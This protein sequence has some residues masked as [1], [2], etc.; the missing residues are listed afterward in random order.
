MSDAFGK[1]AGHSI[2][3][4][5]RP[6]ARRS[7]RRM[8][9]G[10]ITTVL[11]LAAACA[12]V[13][14]VLLQ[15]P[16]TQQA[17]V[18]KHPVWDEF[19]YQPVAGP[20]EQQF[21]ILRQAAVKPGAQNAR[22]RIVFA[23]Q[24]KQNYYFAE[25]STQDVWLGKVENGFELRMGT[26]SGKGLSPAGSHEVLIKRHSAPIQVAV[27]GIVVATAYDDT[28]GAGDV[29]FGS[30]GNE[31]TF[32][33]KNAQPVGEVYRSDDFM[34]NEGEQ[35]LWETASGNWQVNAI[36]NPT[37]STNAFYYIGCG[38]PEA[39]APPNADSTSSRTR[40]CSRLPAAEIT[41]LPGV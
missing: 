19:N 32:T 24:D 5:A 18:G 22:G 26:H 11:L 13:A 29:A 34:R 40:A 17:Q 14:S 25:V 1:R 4:K 31:I 23:L 16:R 37:M 9:T 2:S 38:S 21:V 10:V 39:A 27:D 6:S 8:A 28:F 36:N 41:K 15:A 7:G 33:G 20:K 35:G 30:I 12:V 3:E